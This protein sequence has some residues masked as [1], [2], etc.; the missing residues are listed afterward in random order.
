MRLGV[1]GQRGVR[2][3]ANEVHDAKCFRNGVNF[4]R[5]LVNLFRKA[6]LRKSTFLRCGVGEV[7]SRCSLGHRSV[8]LGIV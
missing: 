4:F 3:N 6:I 1:N 7:F 5:I 2:K 8:E